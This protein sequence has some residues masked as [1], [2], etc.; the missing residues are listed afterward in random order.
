MLQHLCLASNIGNYPWN[1]QENTLPIRPQLARLTAPQQPQSIVQR[2]YKPIL[3]HSATTGL[4][5]S[6][7]LPRT[8][9][10]MDTPPNN[11]LFP[12]PTPKPYNNALANTTNYMQSSKMVVTRHR[13]LLPALHTKRSTNVSNNK[14]DHANA[15]TSN[16][17]YGR[18]MHKCCTN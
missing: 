1:H 16:D 7:E 6:T 11:P 9:N 10:Y 4:Q 14:Q 12:N 3:M 13:Y 18:H 2:T 15:N 17:R 5:P 8:S